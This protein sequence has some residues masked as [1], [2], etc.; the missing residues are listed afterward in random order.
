M[1]K[2]KTAKKELRKSGRN[3]VRNLARQA[4]LKGTLK[5]FRREMTAENLSTSYKTLDKLAKSGFIKKNKANR[6]KS[7][8]TK[9]LAKTV[10]SK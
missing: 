5:T 3:R 6:L 2:T 10:A 4:K 9:R 7:R 1:P 8:L